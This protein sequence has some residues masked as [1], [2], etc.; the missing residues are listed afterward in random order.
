M[1][2]IKL[3]VRNLIIILLMTVLF[4]FAFKMTVQA[5]V[6][7]ED[8]ILEI[9]QKDNEDNPE[10][11]EYLIT[12][13]FITNV[14]P[15]TNLERFKTNVEDEIKVYEDSTREKEVTT[16]IIKTG[17]V[18][19]YTQNDRLYEIS[20]L[21]DINRD[22]MLNQIDLTREIRDIVNSKKIE[23]EIE[24]ITEDLNRDNEIN[25]KDIEKII[26]Y[27]VY[28]K[29]Q[30]DKFEKIDNPKIEVEGEKYQENRYRGDVIVKIAE[31][32]SKEKNSKTEYKV[33]G[34]IDKEY[35]VID[36]ED[37]LIIDTDGVFKITAYTY[38]INGNKSKSESV[39]IIREGKKSSTY[40][41]IIYEMDVNGEYKEKVEEKTGITGEKVSVN[42]EEREGFTY[43]QELSKVEDVVVA[44]GSTTLKVYY[45]RNKYK[46]I[47]DIGNGISE[48]EGGNT[49]Y[50]GATAKINAVV[51]NGY[52]WSKWTTNSEKIPE[53]TE[54]N[55]II[56]MPAENVTLTANGTINTYTIT[57][58]LA[59]GNIQEGEN[60][61][62][63]TVETESFTLSNPSKEGYTFIGWT[64]SNGDK[65]QT[66][67]T[68]ENGTTENKTYI[69][70]WEANTNTIYTVETYEMNLN[71]EYIKVSEEKMYGET[72]TEVNLQPENKKG[73]SINST[74]SIIQGTIAADGSTI[75][76]VYYNRNKYLLT[77][78]SGY[79][80]KFTITALNGANEEDTPKDE[81]YYY[82]AE[83]IINAE[84]KNGYTWSKWVSDNEKIEETVEKQHII[85]IPDA[86]VT[87]T[88]IATLNTYDITYNLDGGSIDKQNPENYTVETE[89]FTLNNPRKI[90]YTFIG[91]TGS[92]GDT[93]QDEVTIIQGSTDNRT[94]T[95]NW[96]PNTDTE[97]KVEVYEMNL[98]G[99]YIKESEDKRKGETYTTVSIEVENREGFTC[100]DI[101][102]VLS[103]KIAPDGSTVLKIYY[104]RNKYELTLRAGYGIE[105]VTGG[106]NYYYGANITAN[107]EVKAGYTWSNWTSNS[108]K[109][110]ENE[111]KEYAFTI[112]AENVTL[113]ANGT[114]NTYTI[115]YDLAGGN[116][117]TGI[118][119]K[120]EYTVETESFTLNNPSKVGYTF[121]GWTGSNGENP[122][123]LIT[124]KKV[125]NMKL[126]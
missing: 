103:A 46:L 51:K 105:S 89:S 74:L 85:T 11:T 110:A 68:I 81:N 115:T 18:A 44:D 101:E 49:Y 83:V 125:L 116:L 99:E 65:P 16:G 76:K 55:Y 40:K 32:N 3:K 72:A 38:G 4:C 50:Y 59:G 79:G 39:L 41:E 20:V 28:N 104:S 63:Y 120:E 93:P 70:N 78:N 27:I 24:K 92:N 36:S 61:E 126:V 106:E 102:S 94:Y 26:D 48:V 35:K 121:I 86:S 98:E 95:A 109:V 31:Q 113:T 34:S 8:E 14:L 43:N 100:D 64:G 7:N 122:E 23:N 2:K 91:W 118:T 53:S 124:L 60:P 13:K 117:S 82:G 33:I 71:G 1:K 21:G 88:A 17:M 111:A 15:N 96:V 67:V 54:K 69:A 22:G 12:D 25:K 114:I 87:L 47:T 97:Y 66:T 80:I 5:K 6:E 75:L 56:T 90:G 107:A 57:Y 108:E 10:S 123:S 73:F 19:I 42:I 52:T 112:P 30:L 58:D 62:N 119:N 29:I 84:V 77:A 45:G 37:E 9:V